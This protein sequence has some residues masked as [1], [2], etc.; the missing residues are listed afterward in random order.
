MLGDTFSEIG[1]LAA[2]IAFTF[3]VIWLCKVWPSKAMRRE[4]KRRKQNER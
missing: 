3:L 2:G 4:R 1:R